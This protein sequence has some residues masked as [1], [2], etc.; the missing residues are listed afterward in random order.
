MANF[1]ELEQKLKQQI[2]RLKDEFQKIRSGRAHAGVI[3]NIIVDHYGTKQPVKALGTIGVLNAQTLTVEPWDKTALEPIAGAISKAQNGLSAV[4]EGERVR[5]P[6]PPLSQERREEFVKFATQK[7]EDAK[8][9]IRRLRDEERK[10]LQKQE[11]N[12]DISKD[13]HFKA[14]ESLDKI[15][16]EYFDKIDELRNGKEKELSEM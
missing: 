13:E 6:F 9:Q 4:V 5:I 12:K 8:I 14:K 7:A 11:K 10:D 16:K 2:E 15:C 3:E 1:P